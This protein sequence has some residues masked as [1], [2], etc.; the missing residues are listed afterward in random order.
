MKSEATRAVI[1]RSRWLVPG[2]L[3]GGVL[4]GATTLAASAAAAVCQD[5]K[6][7]SC[8]YDGWCGGIEICS[9]GHWSLCEPIEDCPPPQEVNPYGYL[10]VVALDQTAQHVEVYG[11]AIDPESPLTSLNVRVIVDGYQQGTFLANTYRPDVGSGNYHGY[12]FVLPADTWGTHRVCVTAVNIGGGV[13]KSLGCKWYDV[14]PKVTTSWGQGDV[15]RCASNPVGDLNALPM[16]RS[17]FRFVLGP[18]AEGLDYWF[19]EP[20]LQGVQR[21]AFGDGRSLI[22]SRS[23]HLGL[24][25]VNMGSQNGTGQPF[26]SGVQSNDA[27]VYRELNPDDRRNYGSH[28]H[29]GHMGGLQTMGRTLAFPVESPDASNLTLNQKTRVMFYEMGSPASPELITSVKRN[30]LKSP[31]AGAV[32]ITRLETGRILMVVGRKDSNNLDFYVSGLNGPYTWSHRYDWNEQELK[33]QIG[34]TTFADYQALN[35]VTGCD[36]T[37]FLVGT[38]R[39]TVGQD[40][41]DLF[42]VEF[43]FD[44]GTSSGPDPR[45]ILTKVAKNHLSCSGDCNLDASGGAYVTP[46]GQLLLYGTEHEAGGDQ[47][48]GQFTVRAGQF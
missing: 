30:V 34:D 4:M 10:D 6:M 8:A 26:V 5:G 1:T 2:L 31:E 42:R 39:N 16:N 21:L 25:V 24:Y 9:G 40:W 22:V 11:W 18:T 45:V 17:S 19:G 20:H 41:V 7:R 46:S 38:D 27:V 37:L 23:G 33:T 44:P 48:N 47:V 32:G 28:V 35:F 12:S 15:N 3:A 43:R 29:Q 36:G 14:K 13:D